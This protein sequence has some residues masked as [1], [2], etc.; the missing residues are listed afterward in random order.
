MQCKFNCY[1]LEPWTTVDK[2]VHS[3]RCVF[4]I[5]HNNTSS[6]RKVSLQLRC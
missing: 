6:V 3:V 5:P 4:N 2:H 1:T